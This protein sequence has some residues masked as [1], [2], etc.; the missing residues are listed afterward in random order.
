[1]HKQIFS[2]RKSPLN[3]HALIRSI[4][5]HLCFKIFGAQPLCKIP[6][7]NSQYNFCRNFPKKKNRS[8]VK[9]LFPRF[10]YFLLFFFILVPGIDTF[11]H[12]PSHNTHI[13]TD[14]AEEQINLPISPFLCG[15][16]DPA[17]AITNI[18]NKCRHMKN[19]RV[20]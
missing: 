20:R 13:D 7:F 3:A 14:T 1:V 5:A 4:D 15:P 17:L 10:F 12:D 2:Q 11:V 6:P 19:D 18:E 8:V 9:L 16:I